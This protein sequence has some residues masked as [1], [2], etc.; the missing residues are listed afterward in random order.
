LISAGPLTEL[1]EVFLYLPQALLP[2]LEILHRLGHDL[3]T[4]DLSLNLPADVYSLQ[5][6]LRRYQYLE[7]IW[8]EVAVAY[9]DTVPAV[10]W[11]D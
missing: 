8:K 4:C 1:T 3:L 5:F 10:A 11:W 7:R 2:N 6:I 9:T